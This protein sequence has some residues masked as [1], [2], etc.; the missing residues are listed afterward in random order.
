MSVHWYVTPY[1]PKYWEDPE[2]LSPKPTSDLK[3]DIQDFEIYLKNHWS[4]VTVRSH[5]DKNRL[6]FRKKTDFTELAI[7]FS[8]ENQVVQLGS[9]PINQLMC[10][11]LQHY[12]RYINQRYP[13]HFF[14]SSDWNSLRLE[15]ETTINDINAFTGYIDQGD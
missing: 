5:S 13:L 6:F 7:S 2:D 9:N 12:R 4:E 8:N 15:P 14:N 11:F 3:V 10:E 1:D